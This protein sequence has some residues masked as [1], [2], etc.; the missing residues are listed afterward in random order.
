MVAVDRKATD[1]ELLLVAAAAYRPTPP[2]PPPPADDA[3]PS[4]Q[5]G[6]SEC[7]DVTRKSSSGFLG[8]LGR[9]NFMQKVGET[10]QRAER[11]AR[12]AESTLEEARGKAEKAVKSLA[13]SAKFC[14]SSAEQ[15]IGA[16]DA[17][18]LERAERELEAVRKE[19]D[20]LRVERDALRQRLGAEAA[21]DIP[22]TPPAAETATAPVVEDFQSLVEQLLTR[23][24]ELESE[25]SRAKEQSVS[26]SRAGATAASPL[27]SKSEKSPS[28][29]SGRENSGKTSA[30]TP[31]EL[32]RGASGLEA[33]RQFTF[34][35]G[36]AKRLQ[37]P[38]P[39]L[40]A[41]TQARP[42]PCLVAEQRAEQR[43]AAA[44]HAGSA[45]LASRPYP[46]GGAAAKGAAL[47][48][49]H[50]PAGPT[51]GAGMTEASVGD[52]PW[53]RREVITVQVD[54]TLGAS[55]GV[56]LHQ[57][58]EENSLTILMVKQ[59]CL[60]A[61][62]NAQHPLTAVH[63]GDRI[64]RVNGEGG[65]AK[66]LVEKL[67]QNKVLM[68]ALARGTMEEAARATALLASRPRRGPP[69][70]EAI[71]AGRPQ[72][73][74]GLPQ[75]VLVRGSRPAGGPCLLGGEE[76]VPVGAG[77]AGALDARG[78][79]ATM[80]WE[81]QPLLASVPE[82]QAVD[83]N[84]AE[85]AAPQ[86]DEAEEEEDEESE[87]GQEDRALEEEAVAPPAAPGAPAAA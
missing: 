4:E 73:T 12:E 3:T 50:T 43:E 13:T 8:K 81:E 54:R 36:Q 75:Q 84:A 16:Q 56:E 45:Q 40:A 2:P 5:D 23:I 85:A 69:P 9:A 64:I 53:G 80:P 65:S 52:P 24:G 86:V 6:E 46:A 10:R 67:M 17:S 83:E 28:I 41:A 34:A 31:V 30:A 78:R 39:L 59:G 47:A 68:L 38:V 18:A 27:R 25:L 63:V 15:R 72:P 42:S 58:R 22:I 44:S 49:R 1:Q 71:V 74:P 70:T 61:D 60:V 87:E 7:D 11:L 66:E 26:I 48:V 32:P 82:E 77:A 62:W 79:S 76:A 29:G 51:G 21:S 19:R 37:D 14:S 35:P 57:S 55:L 33:R 20:Q